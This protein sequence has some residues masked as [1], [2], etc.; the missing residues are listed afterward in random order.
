MILDSY[1]QWFDKSFERDAGWYAVE[2]TDCDT[3]I[4]G[5]HDGSNENPFRTRADAEF[6]RAHYLRS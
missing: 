1:T 6:Y 3:I 4:C 5:D 2:V